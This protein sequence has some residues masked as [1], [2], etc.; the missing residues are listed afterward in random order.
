MGGACSLNNRCGFMD[1]REDDKIVYSVEEIVRAVNSQLKG[2]GRIWMEAEISEF[3]AHQGKHWYFSVKDQENPLALSCVMFQKTNMLLDWMPVVGEKVQVSGEISL[4]KAKLQVVVYRMKKVGL[5]N[6]EQQF[7]QLQEKLQQEG[8]FDQGRKR[9]IPKYPRTIGIATSKDSAA[10]QDIVRI[11]RERLPNAHLILA[12]CG[13]EGV[14]AASDIVRA[15]HLLQ[16][17]N[18]AEVIIVGRG[19]GSRESLMAFNE[20]KVVRAIANSRI[21][22]VCAV[23]HESDHSLSD[24]VADKRAATPTHA[25][26]LVSV[27]SE[28]DLLAHVEYMR[29]QLEMTILRYIRQQRDILANIR[30]RSPKELLEQKKMRLA[31]LQERLRACTTQLVLQHKGQLQTQSAKL[32]SLN[33][34]EVLHRGYSVSMKNGQS[35]VSVEQIKKGDRL[36]LLFAHGTAI[37]KVESIQAEKP[38]GTQLSLFDE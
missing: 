3:T 1:N 21:P 32:D 11:L 17:D 9:D 7:R 20:E 35:V 24:L 5:G 22:T 36:E 23:G 10:M 38:S 37:V 29:Q 2:I 31:Q 13:T 14:S 28:E 12:H 33:P 30:P 15:M 26:E 34:T 4:Y 6:W 8:L 19:G 25:A 27:I 18:R 16:A